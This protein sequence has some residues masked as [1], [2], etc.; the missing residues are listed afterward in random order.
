MPTV[1]EHYKNLFEVT[2]PWEVRHVAEYIGNREVRVAI[3]LADDARVECPRCGRSV[4]VVP[5][6]AGTGERVKIETKFLHYKMIV[7]CPAPKGLCEAHG[8]FPVP[9]PLDSV[10]NL[11]ATEAVPVP[12]PVPATPQNLPELEE[13]DET[14]ESLLGNWQPNRGESGERRAHLKQFI[15]RGKPYR[16]ANAMNAVIQILNALAK[17]DA[18]FLERLS[19]HPDM[20]SRRGRRIARTPAEIYPGRPDLQKC[21][22]KLSD[23]WLI[24]TNISNSIKETILRAAADICGLK[25]GEDIALGT[26]S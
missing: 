1:E 4:P 22:E 10:K 17:E 15:F 6:D 26:N 9:T 12:L 19:Q 24:G 7:D 18:S 13:G 25:Y 21:N 5:D 2:P 11:L 23:G 16:C 14:L 20:Q 8:E 3:R